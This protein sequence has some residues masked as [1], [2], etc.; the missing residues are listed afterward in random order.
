MIAD[1]VVVGAGLAGLS[2]A[3]RLAEAGRRV[4]VVAKGIGA[5]HLAPP[6]IDV[7]GYD[8]ERVDSPAEALPRFNARHADHPYARLGVSGVAE[9]VSWFSARADSLDF[10]GTI[11]E[12]F[13][14]PTAVG[15]AKPSAVVPRTMSAGDLRRRGRYLF[16]GF[17]ALKDFYPAL[18]AANLRRAGFE[19]RW[20]E[21]GLVDEPDVN[22]VGLAR[23]FD[24]AAFRERLGRDLRR[25]LEPGEAVGFPA[26]LG[27]ADAPAVFA[28]LQ[29]R[30]GAPVFEVPTLPP[31][32]PGMRLYEA[33]V[34][35]L[36]SAGGRLVVGGPV[37]GAE[38][39]DGRIDAVNVRAAARPVAYRARSFVLASG[40][41]ASGGLELDSHG[42][43]TET[44]F[45]LP[46]AG[47]ADGRPHFAP[48][49]FDPQPLAKAGVAV[50]DALR[51][52]DAEGRPVYGNLHAAGA[53]L[54]GAEPWREAS[55]N[56]IALA[57]GYA[58]ASAILAE[59]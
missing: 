1:T 13:L 57:S 7:L 38:A 39:R 33:L 43:V 48:G 40:G 28:D 10:A 18:L 6:T 29:E 50:D 16:I 37:S 19:A 41:F 30:L 42:T 12:N 24:D 56:G 53:V 35:R 17:P 55:G 3:L 9:A 59:R 25:R 49:V 5:T 27:L 21:L 11:D 22:S 45:G 52:L 14:L 2:A 51:P 8:G 54:A 26:V 44:V 20:L 32:V 23:R 47:V 15:A 58:A 31:S 46:V 36:R 34:A 4:V